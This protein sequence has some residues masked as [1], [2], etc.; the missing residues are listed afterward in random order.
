MVGH[1]PPVSGGYTLCFGETTLVGLSRSSEFIQGGGLATL[2]ILVLRAPPR[3][4][5]HQPFEDLPGEGLDERDEAR[6]AIV[7]VGAASKTG[8]DRAVHHREGA[9]QQV[10]FPSQ[11]PRKR[12]REGEHPLAQALR[13]QHLVHQVRSGAR[14][15][16]AAAAGADH[17]GLAGEGHHAPCAHGSQRSHMKPYAG[18]PQVAS[19]SK[20]LRT[21]S[22][23]GRPLR[24]ASCSARG[25]WR[26]SRLRRTSHP[27]RVDVLPLSR[28]EPPGRNDHTGIRAVMQRAAPSPATLPRLMAPLRSVCAGARRGRGRHGAEVL[29]ATDGLT[30]VLG[31]GDHQDITSPLAPHH[32]A[33][34]GISGSLLNTTTKSSSLSRLEGATTGSSRLTLPAVRA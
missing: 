18:S 34:C 28:A 12:S 23:T 30:R 13:R 20:R 31:T 33:D 4:L 2:L 16:P 1:P 26:S 3:T 21:D 11:Q 24:S 9:T 14:H 17:P 10:R 27:C 22:S 32:R 19:A 29:P 6:P 7:G 15:A 8:P 5:P 25:R